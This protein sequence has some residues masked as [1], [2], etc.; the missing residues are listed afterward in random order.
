MNDKIIGIISNVLTDDDAE[1]IMDNNP[2]YNYLFF[3]SRI[4]A[5]Y[6]LKMCSIFFDIESIPLNLIQFIDVDKLLAKKGI[7]LDNGDYYKIVEITGDDL[8]E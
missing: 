6:N 2:Y 8:F 1:I 7:I 5:A 3:K 4:D